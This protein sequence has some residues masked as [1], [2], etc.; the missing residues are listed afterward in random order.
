MENITANEIGEQ[1]QKLRA[2]L[3]F[4][5]NLYAFVCAKSE[6]LS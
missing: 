2:A 5:H 3:V 4:S 1:R 6:I